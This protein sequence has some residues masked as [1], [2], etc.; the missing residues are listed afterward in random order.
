MVLL[1]HNADLVCAFHSF[2]LSFFFFCIKP[3]LLILSLVIVL[4]IVY[5]TAAPRGFKHIETEE[6]NLTET[7][8]L[9]N[10][11]RYS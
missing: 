7:K 2:S 9:L 3:L 1:I 10:I 4:A 6:E 8:V 5:V 11:Y